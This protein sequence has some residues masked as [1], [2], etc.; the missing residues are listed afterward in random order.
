MKKQILLTFTLA[1]ACIATHAQI[2]LTKS[3][4]ELLSGDEYVTLNTDFLSPGANGNQALWDFSDINCYESKH[5]DLHRSSQT[6]RSDEF[7]D[8]DVAVEDNGNFFYFKIDEFANSYLGMV[9]P[10]AL[11]RFDTP[12]RKIEYPFT[13]GDF[14]ATEYSGSGIYN[15]SVHSVITGNYTATADAWGTLMLPDGV[16]LQNVLRVQTVD[17]ITETACSSTTFINQ[18]F[19]WYA[20]E[21]RYPLFV[22]R[23]STKID[24]DGTEAVTR[25][26]YY[27]AT[28]VEDIVSETIASIDK[29][30]DISDIFNVYPNPY[31]ESVKISYNLPESSDVSIE[32]VNEAGAVIDV[33]ASQKNEKGQNTLEYKP[34]RSA[35]GFS[36]IRFTINGKVFM[37]KIVKID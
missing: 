19:L 35:N 14:T 26:S 34:K 12:I 18:K 21:S 27:N 25:K 9:T 29:A 2:T 3:S 28:A 33:I 15:G 31:V 23:I 11:I 24:A 6:F 13:Y 5:T 32:T 7:P 17:T 30:A 37:K 10:T 16:A 8:A 36:F 20:A 22:T 1:F 4:H